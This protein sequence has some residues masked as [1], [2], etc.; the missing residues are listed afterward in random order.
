MPRKVFAAYGKYYL[1]HLF[2]RCS[3]AVT[4]NVKAGEDEDER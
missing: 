1:E 3:Y 4:V 2:T